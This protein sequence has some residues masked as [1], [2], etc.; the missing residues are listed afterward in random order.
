MMHAHRPELVEV[1]LVLVVQLTVSG[2]LH[3]EVH[4]FR[5]TSHGILLC[6]A[7]VHFH[8]LNIQQL[9]HAFQ[10]VEM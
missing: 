7:N 3:Y 6:V 4:R 10:D 8:N 5:Q 9:L 1:L 2:V